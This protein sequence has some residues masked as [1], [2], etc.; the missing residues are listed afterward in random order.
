MIAWIK[1]VVDGL[2]YAHPFY[3]QTKHFFIFVE[4]RT[5]FLEVEQDKHLLC[6]YISYVCGIK[7]RII[8]FFFGR[9]IDR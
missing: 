8:P 7:F 9:L 2:P 4:W 1:L 6:H 5:D 3:T